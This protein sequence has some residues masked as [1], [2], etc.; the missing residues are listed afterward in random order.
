M[1]QQPNG[2]KPFDQGHASTTIKLKTQADLLYRMCTKTS[3]SST[4]RNQERLDQTLKLEK[5]KPK[6][7]ETSY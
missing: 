5:Q 3:I 1:W 4:H 6:V 2:G 7:Q